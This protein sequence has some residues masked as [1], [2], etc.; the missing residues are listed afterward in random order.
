M[1]HHFLAVNWSF[2]EYIEYWMWTH[3]KNSHLLP[4]RSVQCDPKYF[5]FVRDYKSNQK[6][7]NVPEYPFPFLLRSTKQ[8]SVTWSGKQN[9]LG[10]VLSSQ[11]TPPMQSNPQA[12][13]KSYGTAEKPHLLL[14]GSSSRAWMSWYKSSTSCAIQ[15]VSVFGLSDTSVVYGIFDWWWYC[16]SSGPLSQVQVKKSEPDL[17]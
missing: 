4:N 7:E 15:S 17:L 8:K 2:T 3:R 5:L 16:F 10:F 11:E 1:Y 6:Q 12:Q 9:L 14:T 13:H